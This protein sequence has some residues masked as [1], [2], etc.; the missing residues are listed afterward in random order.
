MYTNLT[1]QP[2]AYRFPFFLSMGWAN[3]L[4]H[5]EKKKPYLGNPVALI[6]VKNVF[7]FYFPALKLV[8]K[9]S[10]CSQARSTFGLPTLTP[11]S[12]VLRRN[13]A[14]K[15]VFERNKPH[16]NVGTIGHVD[17]GKTTLTA[18]I[19]KGIAQAPYPLQG[20]VMIFCL[21]NPSTMSTPPCHVFARWSILACLVSRS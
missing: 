7:Y 21:F 20:P 11:L 8:L 16:C 12:I 1:H 9:Q 13:Y 5:S 18:A 2:L 17:H 14:E 10:H 6:L 3:L 4:H 15:Q 19:T